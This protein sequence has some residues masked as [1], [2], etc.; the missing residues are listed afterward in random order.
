MLDTSLRTS[1]SELEDYYWAGS[2]RRLGITGT[3]TVSLP[4]LVELSYNENG[5]CAEM[6]VAVDVSYL[7]SG[8]KVSVTADNGISLTGSNGNTITVATSQDK[9]VWDSDNA[10]DG[11]VSIIGTASDEVDGETFSGTLTLTISSEKSFS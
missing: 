10:S 7:E 2:N 9:T 6:P 11:M 1:S 4:A 5:Y 3:Y 8:D